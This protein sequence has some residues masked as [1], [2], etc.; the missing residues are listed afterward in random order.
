MPPISA[1][2]RVRVIA[3]ALV[4]G[5]VA[6][7]DQPAAVDPPGDDDLPARERR[8][9]AQP[10]LPNVTASSPMLAACGTGAEFHLSDMNH[11]IGTVRVSNDASTLFVTYSVTSPDWF[12]SDTRLAVGK[13]AFDIPQDDDG[14]PLPWSFPYIGEHEP[15]IT[16][17]TYT[18]PLAD[19][20]VT[21]GQKVIVAAMAGVV[22]PT[23]S[24]Y[25]GPWEWL[26]MWGLR[27]TTATPV[28]TMHEYVIGSCGSEPPPPPPPT[29]TGLVTITFDD[30]WEDTYT[31]AF[32]VLRDLGIRANV[33]VNPIAVD[34]GWTTYMNLAQLRALH[35]AGWNMVSHSWSHP[36]LTRLSD[37]ELH[38]ELRDS[39]AWIE[40]K[41]F[42]PAK[43]FIVPF[44]AWGDRERTAIA[45]Y[46]ANARGYSV[47]QFSPPRFTALPLSTAPYNIYGYEPEFAPFTTASGRAA[48][49]RHVEHAI[50]EGKHVDIFFHHITSSQVPA[51]RE[52]M[53]QMAQ[54]KASIRTWN[55][56]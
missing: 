9:I 37:A 47:N 45:Q 44:H 38:R 6:A 42:G 1:L 25:E 48:T 27:S 10:V 16:S 19:L 41:G 22:H 15:V 50:Q 3:A 21:A 11:T 5:L 18:I 33:A 54:Y 12:I 43:T 29:T 28:Q 49:M 31:N 24:S 17:H 13:T 35:A 34:G 14:T 56:M 52:L 4:G 30:G 40:G 32:P 7:C 20:G 23:T 2:R 46:Y 8:V 36:D 39:K 55:E 26:V 51:F 53:T